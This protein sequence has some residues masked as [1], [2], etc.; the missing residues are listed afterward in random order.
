MIRAL[1]A[2]KSPITSVLPALFAASAYAQ[3]AAQE[4]DEPTNPWVVTG[5]VIFAVGFCGWYFWV[6]WKSH[7]ESSG[8][9]HSG[10]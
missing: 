9:G 1:S 3:G 2:I 10:T 7:K 8:G 6:N 5:I 4:I